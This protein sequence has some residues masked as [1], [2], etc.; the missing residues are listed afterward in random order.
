MHTDI[1]V[2]LSCNNACTHC[3]MSP[4]QDRMTTEGVGLDD[5]RE[6]VE[7]KIRAA[8]T[9]GYDQVVLTGGEV[10]MRA[11]FVDL[12]K[13][14]IALGLSVS[15][16]T[17]ARRLSDPAV[18]QSLSEVARSRVDFVVAYHSADPATHDSITRRQGSHAQTTEAI[19]GLR[20][21]GFEVCGKTVLSRANYAVLGATLEALSRLEID[22]VIVSFPH[23][24]GFNTERFTAVV[25][26]YTTIGDALHQALTDSKSMGMRIL[27][28]TFPFCVMH[29]DDWC[30]N[31][32][33]V[34]VTQETDPL[35]TVISMP[36]HQ[37]LIDWRKSRKEIKHKSP[38]CKRCL[39]DHLCE[40]PW[41]EYPEH[42]GFTEF[43]PIED[44]S[45]VE[46]FITS[47]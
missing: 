37:E 6:E 14:A 25:P 26:T 32:D 41:S 1:K 24:E 4:A 42:F 33:L 46:N 20:A 8:A 13:F 2:G 10:T 44:P 40:G 28:E 16:Q 30:L 7:L 27:C 35:T 19:R 47:L 45:R 11:D 17:N 22:E 38:K 15:V 29:E 23:A 39:L 5:S 21:L 31:L 9:S 3:I 18:L 43:I 12:V 36:G 34:H